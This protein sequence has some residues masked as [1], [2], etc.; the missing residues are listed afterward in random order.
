MLAT[1]VKTVATRDPNLVSRSIKAALALFWLFVP[2]A[3]V[4]ASAVPAV[5]ELPAGRFIAGSDAG[6]RELAY[7]LDEKAYGH[8]VTRNNGWYDDE[9]PRMVR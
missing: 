1:G 8:S 6:E 4:P 7:R 5:V 3:A 9:A 2:S